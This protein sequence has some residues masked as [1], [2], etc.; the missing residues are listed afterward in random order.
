[1]KDELQKTYPQL[2]EAHEA[3]KAIMLNTINR[4]DLDPVY[5][6]GVLSNIRA[7]LGEY[8]YEHCERLYKNYND[9]N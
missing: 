7:V 2:S 8:E 6:H 3:L 5:K 1:M 9:Q 4:K